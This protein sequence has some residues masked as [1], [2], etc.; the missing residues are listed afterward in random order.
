MFLDERELLSARSKY[1][2]VW[3]NIE[4]IIT[5][6]Q[7]LIIP[8]VLSIQSKHSLNKNILHIYLGMI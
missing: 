4:L 6:R 3:S 1:D 8:N 7:L 5:D 2:S